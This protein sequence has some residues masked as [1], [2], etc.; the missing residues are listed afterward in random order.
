MEKTTTNN[1]KKKNSLA[2]NRTRIASV[3][4][5]YTSRCTTRDLLLPRY[6]FIF[7]NL[8]CRAKLILWF[9]VFGGRQHCFVCGEKLRRCQFH[10]PCKI[11]HVGD[12][13]TCAVVWRC[14]RRRHTRPH[15]RASVRHCDPRK[16]C[17]ARCLRLGCSS[18]AHTHEHI[19]RARLQLGDHALAQNSEPRHAL[20]CACAQLSAN[21][22][23]ISC[24]AN[25][26]RSRDCEPQLA[27][28]G[29]APR[30]ADAC[31]GVHFDCIRDRGSA[32]CCRRPS[33]RG[34]GFCR[35]DGRH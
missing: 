7:I 5:T 6:T 17:L 12:T 4:T 25:K 29:F 28:A 27:L 20:G 24:L 16:R 15:R 34:A 31:S 1:K 33:C 30:E 3:K 21:G 26:L 35:R 14:K 10:F 19:D 23:P 9:A 32:G 18:S 11:G 13:R 2:G 22:L 8:A